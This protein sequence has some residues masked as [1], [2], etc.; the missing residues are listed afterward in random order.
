MDTYLDYNSHKC[1]NCRAC[2][3]VCP[4]RSIYIT[5]FEDDGI[6]THHI[7]RKKESQY[8]GRCLKNNNGVAPCEEICPEGLIRVYQR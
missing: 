4:E 3:V 5:E 2:K 1:L 7:H 6:I 8:C